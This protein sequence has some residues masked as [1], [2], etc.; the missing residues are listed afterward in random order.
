MTPARSIHPPHAHAAE[1]RPNRAAARAKGLAAVACLLALLVI[2]CA[3]RSALLPASTAHESGA[4]APATLRIAVNT[5]P[6]NELRLL[7]GVGATLAQRI[8]DHRDREGPFAAVED[9]EAVPG[10]GQ[11]TR[12]RLRPWITTLPA[13][14]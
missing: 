9:L 7:P 1:G 12:R 6:R 5:A 10:I 2:G 8:V 11:V 13:T 14:P 4:S 3:T